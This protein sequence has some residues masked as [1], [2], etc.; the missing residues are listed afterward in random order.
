MTTWQPCCGV[1]ALPILT[2]ER[3]NTMTSVRAEW[4]R[5][6]ISI[7]ACCHSVK[8]CAHAARAFRSQQLQG[9][10]VGRYVD[11]VSSRENKQ[12]RLKQSAFLC[13]HAAFSSTRFDAFF[14]CNFTHENAFKG[15]WWNC[16]W[17]GC[18][19]VIAFLVMFSFQKG[20]AWPKWNRFQV[21]T[22][23]YDQLRV[24]CF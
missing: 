17:N 5:R 3:L 11:C 20:S 2:C 10:A 23:S 22:N 21:W 9:K 8:H 13:K 16:F 7:A 19:I 14:D 12:R 4:L 6:M 1:E 15:N 24:N 18:L